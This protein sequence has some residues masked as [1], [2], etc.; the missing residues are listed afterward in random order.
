M[1]TIEPRTATVTIYGG[2]YLDRIRLLERKAEAAREAA[3]DVRTID[4]VPEYLTLAEQH[5][6]LVAEAE[7]KAT[8]IK[9]R[10]LGRREWKALVAAHPAREGNKSDE[11]VG[12]N[13]DTFKDALVPASIAE[14]AGFGEDDLDALSDIDFDRLYFTAFALNRAPGGDPKAG[15][16]S[17]MTQPNDETSN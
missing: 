11:S 4:E 6:A 13:E 2:D 1:T 15:L 3:S 14:P 5:D 10:A 17:R 7:E 8:H 9:L 16:V 12:V